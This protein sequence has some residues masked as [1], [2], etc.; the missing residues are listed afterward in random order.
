MMD[1]ALVGKREAS[2][3]EAPEARRGNL[4][5]DLEIAPPLRGSQ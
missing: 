2:L 5:I 3:R 4:K 1:S